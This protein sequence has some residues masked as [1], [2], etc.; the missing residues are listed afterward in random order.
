MPMDNEANSPYVRTFAILA[1]LAILAVALL[2]VLWGL[3]PP[4][5]LPPTAPPDVFSAG[6]AEEVL[7]AVVADAGPRPIGSAGHDLVRERLV[8]R[9][10]AL[11]YVPTIQEAIACRSYN[12]AGA[13]CGQVQNVLAEL[14][15][16]TDGPA[17]LLVAHYDSGGVSPGVADNGSGVVV[18]LEVARLLQ[19]Q[20]PQRN[21]VILLF[22]DGEEVGL[23]GARAFV[24]EHPW[25]RR[26]GAVVNLEAR[27]TSG[28]VLMFETSADN[29]W[30][31]DAYASTPHPSTNSLMY[32]AYKAMPNETDFS[33]FKAAG[34]PGLNLA[35]IEGGAHYHTPL[36]N[37]DNLDRGSLQHQGETTLA[38][39]RALAGRDLAS[40]P[41]G[42]A[43][44]MDLLGRA[45]LRWPAAWTPPL[46]VLSLLLPGTAAALILRQRLALR[47][48][49][50]GL[51]AALL[52]VALPILLG[53][54]LTWL[55]STIAGNSTPWYAYPLPMRLA[56]WGGALLCTLLAGA[57]LGRPAGFWGLALGTW[58]FWGLLALL[59]AL[60]VPGAAILLI[61]PALWA[62]L[63]LAVV[64][65]T[66]L[67]ASPWAREVAALAAAF[68]AALVGLQLA[69]QFE[70]AFRFNA[71]PTVT[72]AVGLVA[73]TLLPLLA[74]PPG[75]ARWQRILVLAAAA[76]TL[77]GT[78]AAIMV[79]PFSTAAPRAL[80]LYHVADGDTGTAYWA[81]GSRLETL[82]SPLRE[83]FDA[84]PQAVFPW[85]TGQRPVALSTPT[86]A[87]APNLEVLSTERGDT[88]RTVRLRLRSP[89]GGSEVDLYVPIAGLEAVTVA[90]QELPVRAGDSWNNFYNLWCYGPG[91]DG[92]EV[93]LRFSD[94]A[95]QEA[96]VVDWT[97]GL[98]SGGERFA[99]ARPAWTTPGYEGDLTAIIR[100]IKF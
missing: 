38:L 28:R 52:S 1:G 8:D 30:L 59:T 69:L 53:L 60:L 67:A 79:P 68:P 10:R 42:D 80:N 7:R 73:G 9:L 91:C 100:R 94:T 48:L 76:I 90:G 95:P 63:L 3:R 87:P 43:A 6:R 49:G 96:I 64:A 74:L 72:L 89:R 58:L 54:G 65:L 88:G 61:V 34:L 29:A 41:R 18:L 51:L 46:A 44:Y 20:G 66:P 98:P 22:S 55:V 56:L 97:M 85:S 23:L 21:P 24:D 86:G 35:Y 25:A 39:A 31:L 36:D 78:L 75:R 40:P 27:G 81:A 84:Q 2:L 19:A 82:P 11:G 16:Q 93:T 4:A 26:I 45:L 5:P 17:L 50:Q 12:G 92:L 33:V 14:P 15:G 77:V 99:Q 37:L 70:A 62:G 32:E 47:A 57:R 83:Q 71:S 13:L